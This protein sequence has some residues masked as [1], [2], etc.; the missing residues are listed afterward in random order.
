[1]PR[2]AQLYFAKNPQDVYD[3]VQQGVEFLRSNGYLKTLPD[4]YL[5]LSARDRAALEVWYRRLR[6]DSEAEPNVRFIGLR[7]YFKNAIDVL[8]SLDSTHS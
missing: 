4:R 2:I 5:N 3:A 8:K 6:D 7:D 1:M